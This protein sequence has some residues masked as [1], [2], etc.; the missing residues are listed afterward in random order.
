M[1]HYIHHLLT[2]SLAIAFALSGL[3][4]SAQTQTTTPF[5]VDDLLDVK[6]TSAVDLS[7]DGR[8]LAATVA[9]LRDRIGI[10]NSRFGD[11]TYLSPSLTEVLIIDTQSSKS[12]K[13]IPDKRQARAMKWSP[14]GSRLAVLVLKQN[15]FEPMIWE[16]ASGKWQ[17]VA[18]PPTKVASENSELTWTPAS[19]QLRITVRGEEWGKQARAKFE[20]ETRAPIV[21][22]SSKE[23]FL[24]WE[25]L[26]RMAAIR[27][28][29]AFDVKTG[30]T[31]EL[32]AQTK[33][34]SY[35][36]A[37]HGSFTP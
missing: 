9:S 33:S 6:N 5:N 36:L 7:E 34:N 31:R 21:V 29:V 30:K 18:L 22:Q 2:F 23:P 14:D 24:A 19:D 20:A 15:A 35:D 13:L 17:T 26:R 25:N 1:R 27:T 37:G 12:Q 32:I 4:W 10:D 28:L 8:W 3:T 16:R 11:P